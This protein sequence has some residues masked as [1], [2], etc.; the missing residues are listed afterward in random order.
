MN[1]PDSDDLKSDIDELVPDLVAMRRD[2]QALDAHAS[3]GAWQPNQAPTHQYQ[4]S[5]HR[6]RHTHVSASFIY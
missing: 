1:M 3:R 6:F 5:N 4:T 2:L